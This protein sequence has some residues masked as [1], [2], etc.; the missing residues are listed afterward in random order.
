M[1][2]GTGKLQVIFE[3]D[4]RHGAGG[5]VA[6]FMLQGQIEINR[7]EP[8]VDGQKCRVEFLTGDAID[9]AMEGHGFLKL[10]RVVRRGWGEVRYQLTDM[11]GWE[12]GD[13][14]DDPEDEGE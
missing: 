5:A 14:D 7:L 11:P 3:M 2:Q 4:L 6:G 13:G 12:Q 9:A 8:W 1:S 10:G